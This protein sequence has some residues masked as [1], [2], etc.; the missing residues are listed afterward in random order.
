MP[1]TLR[2]MQADLTLAR[3][4]AAF[5]M[6]SDLVNA[7]EEADLN[8]TLAQPSNTMWDQIWCVVGA[9]ESH[10]RAIEAR[11][12]VGFSCSLTAADRGSK[13][14]LQEALETSQ[15]A[16]LEALSVAMDEKNALDLLLHE[17][18]HHGQLIRFMYGLQLDFPES[19]RRRWN[20]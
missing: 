12:W 9:R 2:M 1:H 18:Q 5:D 7:V 14:P 19:W 6:T 17:T 13:G 3:I 4:H 15:R 16:V 8:R 10:V 20:V 11:E